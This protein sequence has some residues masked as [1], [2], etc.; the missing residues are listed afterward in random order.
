M[1][2]QVEKVENSEIDLIAYKNV[3]HDKS[4]ILK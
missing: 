3:V 2:R 4:G 1:N